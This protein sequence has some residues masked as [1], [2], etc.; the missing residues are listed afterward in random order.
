MVSV[1]L[2]IHAMS[3][4]RFFCIF[5][6]DTVTLE[7]NEFVGHMKKVH[8]VAN[9]INF[10]LQINFVD[11]PTK[12]SLITHA[13]RRI[14]KSQRKQL[15]ECSFC[16]SEEQK[17]NFSLVNLIRFQSH[18]K[19]VHVISFE[20][21]LILVMHLMESSN[22][23]GNKLGFP[24]DFMDLPDVLKLKKSDNNFGLDIVKEKCKDKKTKPKYVA[25][26]I[27]K[28]EEKKEPP[29]LIIKEMKIDKLSEI[30]NKI[31]TLMLFDETTRIWHC[32][33][34]Q[35]FKRNIGHVRAHV[36]KHLTGL[37]FKSPVCPLKFARSNA[38]R[39]HIIQKHSQ[40]IEKGLFCGSCRKCFIH[41]RSLKNHMTKH[42]Q[43]QHFV[44]LYC[45]FYSD[46]DTLLR[47]HVKSKH[48]ANFIGTYIIDLILTEVVAFKDLNSNDLNC[49][50]CK[51]LCINLETLKNHIRTKHWYGNVHLFQCLVCSK[52]FNAEYTLRRHIKVH[53]KE[54][55]E[56]QKLEYKGKIHTCQQCSK[57][58][59]TNTELRRHEQT[60][61]TD[62]PFLCEHCPG[63]FK[64][65]D[66]LDKHYQIHNSERPW[67][68]EQCPKTFKTARSL[69]NH[70][71][72]H[73]T[74]KIHVCKKCNKS[75]KILQSLKDNIRKVHD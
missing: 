44:C 55:T 25:K 27:L 64:S 19:E 62:R 30:E 65:Y 4:L 8:C 61:S 34:C 32:R 23:I 29:K 46:Y 73:F 60:H 52:Y 49:V 40:T 74:D 10:L 22:N 58:F 72:S 3:P 21:D 71:E 70:M 37:R 67:K 35:Y 45:K 17:S 24:S 2:V 1:L 12:L 57:V 54:K 51:K 5:C 15:F 59:K 9:N 33:Q 14:N 13:K 18:L 39:K 11:K 66:R 6:P 43:G 75:Y 69:N 36:E 47:C 42:T 48:T 16:K 20:L 28:L 53:S 63:T 38:M 31:K 26:G 50:H 68:C 41:E 7:D 56:S